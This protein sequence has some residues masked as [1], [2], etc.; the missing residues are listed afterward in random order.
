M[1]RVEGFSQPRE[2]LI[3]YQGWI[4]DISLSDAEDDGELVPRHQVA[5]DFGRRDLRDVHG[6]QHGGQAHADAAEDAIE[7]EVG[8]VAR[9][10]VADGGEREIPAPMR[11]GPK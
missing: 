11:P 7:D 3:C 10:A 8:H 2:P 1:R 9:T 6:R 4:Q 5:A